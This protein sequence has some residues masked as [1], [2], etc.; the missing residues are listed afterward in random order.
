MPRKHTHALFN[1]C[2]TIFL[3]LA[4]SF[5]SAQTLTT[6]V[7]FHSIN[8]ANPD[9]P[10]VQGRNGDLYGTAEYGGPNKTGIV[11]KLAPSGK[12]STLYSFGNSADG[13]LPTD[14]CGLAS[15]LVLG[16]DGNFYGTTDSGGAYSG[17]SVYRLTPAGVL[18]T[19]Y[20][21][22]NTRGSM[23]PSTLIYGPNG[24]FYG[25][26]RRGGFYGDG[27]VLSLTPS[28]VLTTLYSFDNGY[29]PEA[30]L[31]LGNDGNFYGTTV[32]FIFRISPAG[33]LTG[34]YDL[35]GAVAPL[36]LGRDG[37]LY[38]TAE[39]GYGDDGSVFSITTS[40]SF[41]TLHSFDGN[42]G[43]NPTAG[44]A[45]GSDGNFYGSALNGGAE[46]CGTL[47]SISPAEFTLLFSLDNQTNGCGPAAAM[48]M[49]TNG[50]LYGTTASGGAWGY[51]TVY[52][53]NAHL[54]PFVGLVLGFGRH[55]SA[56]ELLGQGFTGTTAVSF[57]GVPA[58][59]FHVASDTYMTAIVPPGATTGP[60]TVTTPGGSLTSKLSFIIR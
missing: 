47:F 55:G 54:T 52:S 32:G 39:D 30:G 5:A 16:T 56:A 36:V 43:A 50:L 37:T 14:N 31:V 11:F 2:S 26:T 29:T 20:S 60:V 44:L 28:G 3:S 41:T 19:I 12:L 48:V 6:V 34:L 8:G 40:G 22:A 13:C 25:T 35:F 15:G 53:L 21:F 18:T 10:L 51:G 4:C 27:T 17:G 23:V 33:A 1:I 49:H 59:S 9:S 42:D 57:N 46:N 45:L 7:N 24:S 38:G 58:S